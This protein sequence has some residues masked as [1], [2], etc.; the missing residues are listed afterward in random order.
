MNTPN[1][2]APPK[3]AVADVVVGGENVVLANRGAR[4]GAFLL[5]LAIGYAIF[6]IPLI[7]SGALAG[8]SGALMRNDMGAVA[9]V[10]FGVGGLMI[11]A[12]SIVWCVVTIILVARNGQT[13]GKKMVGIKVVRKDGSQAS[14]GRIFWLRNV[15]NVIIAAFLPF[16][17]YYVIDP[18]FIFGERQ[19]CLHDLIADTIVVNA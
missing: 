1:A 4:L 5:D 14:L 2:Y 6:L 8:F 15:V 13:I 19:Q 17:Y 7:V 18:L 12:L 10:F 9:A 16:I 11:V 3:A